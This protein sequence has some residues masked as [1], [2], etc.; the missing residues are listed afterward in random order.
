MPQT[1]HPLMLDWL[2]CAVG[3][4]QHF[5]P[6]TLDRNSS[7]IVRDAVEG[8]DYGR[9]VHAGD[10]VVQGT[11]AV[12]LVLRNKLHASLAVRRN[13]R[14]ANAAEALRGRKRFH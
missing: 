13:R 3:L 8:L 11:R 6:C 5:A 1:F 9:R 2:I 12:V 4:F 10:P 7:K 14:L